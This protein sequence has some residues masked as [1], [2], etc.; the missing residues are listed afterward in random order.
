MITSSIESN[1]LYVNQN[2]I[3]RAHCVDPVQP[4]A[5]RVWRLRKKVYSSLCSVFRGNISVSKDEKCHIMVAFIVRWMLRRLIPLIENHHTSSLMYWP[6]CKCLNQRKKPFNAWFSI[7]DDEKIVQLWGNASRCR[8]KVAIQTGPHSETHCIIS[9]WL[10]LSPPCGPSAMNH[11][12]CLLV[13]LNRHHRNCYCVVWHVVCIVGTTE[14]LI[15]IDV[16]CVVGKPIETP[17]NVIP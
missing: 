7:L 6:R 2:E 1:D 10:I 9:W 11:M 4:R 16:V 15:V 3:I 17:S 13:A 5:I 14:I 12:N 8:H